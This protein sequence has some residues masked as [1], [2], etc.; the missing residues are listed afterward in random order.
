MANEIPILQELLKSSSVSLKTVKEFPFPTFVKNRSGEYIYLS[1]SLLEDADTELVELIKQPQPSGSLSYNYVQ[2]MSNDLHLFEK[3]GFIERIYSFREKTYKVFK[4]CFLSSNEK[5]LAGFAVDIS[6]LEET[7]KNGY[8]LNSIVQNI[9]HPIVLAE[10]NKEKDYPIVFVNDSFSLLTGYLMADLKGT[11]CRV[12]QGVNT[13]EQTK[14]EIKDCLRKGQVFNGII[15]NY[16]KD[17][18]PFLNHLEIKPIYDPKKREITHFLGIQ[19]EVEEPSLGDKPLTDVVDDLPTLVITTSETGVVREINSF[20]LKYLGYEEEEVLDNPICSL[21]DTES[22]L[23]FNSKLLIALKLRSSLLNERL[24]VVKKNGES[25]KFL[26]S[27]RVKNGLF[28]FVLTE[29]L[30]LTHPDKFVPPEGGPWYLHWFAAFY[31]YAF[32]TRKRFVKV[33]FLLFISLSPALSLYYY[34]KY[35]ADNYGSLFSNRNHLLISR[36]SR[37][38]ATRQI[39]EPYRFTEARRLQIENILINARKKSQANRATFRVYE[40]DYT[41]HLVLDLP[42]P[43]PNSKFIPKDFWIVNLGKTG[44]NNLLANFSSQGFRVRDL[45]KLDPESALFKAAK[46]SNTAMIIS[47]PDPN[48][49]Y[50]YISLDFSSVLSEEEQSKVVED[51]KVASS[52][53]SELLSY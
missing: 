23:F 33:A 37:L 45:T 14:Q 48:N 10:N 13:S 1:E 49:S 43:G 42:R 18:T 35:L 52:Q 24:V 8:V 30:N 2:W 22:K 39:V 4:F 46:E 12:L 34:E 25:I 20:A 32:T 11:N 27:A 36:D 47:V 41:A 53:V 17:G 50:F 21:F 6:D 40:S 28:I 5:Y 31:N 38:W 29:I 51:L 9:R 44:Y 16:K 26:V 15:Q 3:D 7:E 19:M